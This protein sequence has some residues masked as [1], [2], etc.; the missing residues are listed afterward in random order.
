MANA[1]KIKGLTVEIGGDTT[2]LGK[3]L[4]DVNKKS[5]D[6]SSELGDINKLLK[7][8]PG[9]T[10]LIAQKQKVLADAISNTG[11]KLDTLRQAEKQ[12]QEQFRRGEVSEEQVRALQREI[13]AT[14]KKM[15]GY[16]RAVKET[17]KSQKDFADNTKEAEHST[18]EWGSTLANVA[19]TGLQAV[20][21]GTTAVV[22]SMVAAA[23]GTREYRTEMGKLETAF[24][25][26]GF[27]AETA[28]SA[29]QE[30]QGVLGETEQ[31]VEAANHLAQLT[32]NEKD[33]AK[34]TG[35]ILP[36]VYAT[37][38]ASLPIEG[39]TEAAN[40]TAK[41]G[42]VTG[43]LADALNWAGV[44]EDAFNESLAECTT[45]QERQALITETLAGLYGDA[46]KAYKETN[47]EVI[48]ANQANEQWT[49]SLAEAGAATEPVLT[50]VK[51]LGATMLSDFLPSITQVTGAFRGM[52]NGESGAAEDLGS[53]LSNIATQLLTKVT[54]LAPS[55]AS[56]AT[57]LVTTLVTTI[58]TMI[59]QLVDTGVSMMV[60]I[61]Q[62][63][64][65]AIPQVAMALRDMIPQLVQS[66]VDGVPL[67][68]QGAV[69]LF[70]S[71]IEAIKLILP[72]LV[73]AI[74]TIV[75]T[76]I[77][78]LMTA[79]PQLIE[80]A[81]QLLLAIVDAI[82]LLLKALLP[83]I[84]LII[85]TLVNGLLD[86]TDTL[87]D[88]AITLFFA[89]VE[90]I[91]LICKELLKNL[92]QIWT[93]IYGVLKSLPS[94]LWDILLKAIGKV[95]DFG[96]NLAKKGA[97]AAKD[98]WDS[99][100]NK[101]KSLP[102]EM[103]KVGKNLVE[104]LWNGIKDMASWIGKKIKGFSDGVLDD[105]KD[106]F[107]IHSPSTKTAWMGKMLAQG[108]AQGVTDNAS[109]PIDAMTD[110]AAEMLDQETQME[111]LNFE[112]SINANFN[113]PTQNTAGGLLAKLDKILKAIERGQ[114]IA[115]DGRALVGATI[116]EY[117]RQLGRKS[118]LAKGGA[119]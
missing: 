89:I 101:I 108:L 104:G 30:L 45:E 19:K 2:K 4:D 20:V 33:L 107:G 93:T 61:L 62:G 111:G 84:P 80:G 28:K 95:A 83:K 7:L 85:T 14:E 29:Y 102:D 48:R 1:S 109:E 77:D 72:P 81:L 78:C 94:K 70:L 21:A 98:L 76:I 15:D 91:P 26:N 40:E 79:V 87:L 54:E 34:W 31:A 16:K 6:I 105:I 59:P 49:A 97:Q 75:L 67:L 18:K 51:M 17:S 115:I 47:A 86:S 10:E 71:L 3:A 46:A 103:K 57:S 90:A 100:V 22:G 119:F 58:V 116:D 9:N 66:L 24:T 92:P 44:S 55:L 52:L 27:S 68:I 32:D 37:F 53:A 64:T 63:I 5:R 74:P 73:E 118:I 69:D 117:D 12:V 65:S 106:F 25:T 38:G 96:K 8:D 56:T 13:I 112:R 43:P 114:V 110:L 88:A 42:Q 99:I 35:D 36:G 11:K 50:D 60:N 41:V 39:L 23:E 113:Q 82:P